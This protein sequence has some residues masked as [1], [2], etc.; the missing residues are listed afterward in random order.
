MTYPNI[1]AGAKRGGQISHM[2]ERVVYLKTTADEFNENHKRLVTQLKRDKFN[3][4]MGWM[5]ALLAP[6]VIEDEEVQ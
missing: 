5:R 1:A 3:C 4:P 2:Y 6:G